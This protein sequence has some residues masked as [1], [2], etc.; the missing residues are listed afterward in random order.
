MAEAANTDSWPSR[1]GGKPSILP[2]ARRQHAHN[3]LQIRT[4]VLNTSSGLTLS[5][6]CLTAL[7]TTPWLADFRANR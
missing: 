1:L 4:A 2:D 3:P 6:Q 5:D 7:S